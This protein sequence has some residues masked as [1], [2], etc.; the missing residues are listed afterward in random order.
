MTWPP[1]IQDFFAQAMSPAACVPDAR[2]VVSYDWTTSTFEVPQHGFF[3]G[4]RVRFRVATSQATLPGPIVAT[5]YYTVAT[6][7]G[8]DFFSCVGLTLSAPVQPQP[9]ALP[10]QNVFSVLEDATPWIVAILARCVSDVQSAAKAYKPPYTGDVPLKLTGIAMDLAAFH[11]AKRIRV[12]SPKF[13]MEDIRLAYTA[14]REDLA[15]LDRGDP[16]AETV[17]DATPDV[18]E[19]GAALATRSDLATGTR[20]FDLVDG[21]GNDLA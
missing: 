10:V 21:G 11:V 15:K 19:M 5:Q 7:S 8:P 20:P 18:A 13:S 14:A 9:G 17:V 16:L 1:T 3:G 12:A 6:P 4:E 2:Q